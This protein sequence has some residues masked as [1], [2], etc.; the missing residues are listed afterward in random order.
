MKIPKFH[1]ASLPLRVGDDVL[2]P[3]REGD[4]RAGDVRAGMGHICDIR[5]DGLACYILKTTMYEN[6]F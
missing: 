4:V 2:P 3:L 1:D 6:I 5:E